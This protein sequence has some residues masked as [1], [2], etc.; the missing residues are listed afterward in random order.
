MA[1]GYH[2]EPFNVGDKVQLTAQ[3]WEEAAPEFREHY[4]RTGTIMHVEPDDIGVM[5]EHTCG[6]W[7][8][9]M[10]GELEALPMPADKECPTCCGEPYDVVSD[11]HCPT[12]EGSGKH[13]GPTPREALEAFLEKVS[14]DA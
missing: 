14:T 11:T 4:S 5:V 12:C 2:G 6:A 13:P 1:D 7:I 3:A 10:P 9:W 8:G